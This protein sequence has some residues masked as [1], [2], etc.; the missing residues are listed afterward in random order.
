MTT[1]QKPQTDEERSAEARR[2]LDRA[3]SE[4]E[5]LGTSALA[6]AARHLAGADAPQDDRLEVWGRRIGRTLG[7]IFALYLVVTLVD[8]FGR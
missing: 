8:H 6:R 2:I 1:P 5:S 7:F 3:A 4:T